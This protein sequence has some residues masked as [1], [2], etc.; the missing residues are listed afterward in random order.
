LF[1]QRGDSLAA[2]VAVFDW[3]FEGRTTVYVIL[4]ATTAF[5]LLVWW[6]TRKR[7]CLFG[8]VLA[9]G[10]TGLYAL[11]DKLIETDRE[12]IVRKI[13]TMIADLNAGRI[14]AAFENI[15]DQFQWKGKNKADLKELAKTYI[16][17]KRVTQFEV[18]D[19]T[20]PES[21]SREAGTASA[22]FQVKAHG[23]KA[24]GVWAVC[25]ATFAF[26]PQ[27]GWRLRTFRLLKPQTTEEWSWQP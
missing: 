17:Q 11:L 3:I 26:D 4:A 8:V 9:V 2:E 5:F 14:D 19:I 20:A 18:W 22:S 10:L 13:S 6:Q 7:W 25:D 15:S 12:Q 21:P 27:K 1:A 23:G 24:E 16:G